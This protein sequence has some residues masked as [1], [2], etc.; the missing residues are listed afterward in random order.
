MT[1]AATSAVAVTAGRLDA[2][3]PG[4]GFD[5]AVDGAAGD[6]WV[7]LSAVETDGHLDTWL[8]TLLRRHG[9]RNVA[10]SM[11][12]VELTLA[13]VG[14]TVGAMALDRRCPDPAVDNLAVR[15]HP[16]GYLER[17]A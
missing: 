12:G 7:R 9:R 4:S 16:D 6:G 17:I 15:P 5:V 10:G 14:P 1:P 3:D 11:L 13:V 2:F 8:A